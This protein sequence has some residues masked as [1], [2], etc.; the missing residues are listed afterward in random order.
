MR[1]NQGTWAW[2]LLATIVV[3]IPSALRAQVTTADI[4][5]TVTDVTGAAVPH[6]TVTITDLGTGESRQ[7]SSAGKGEF[8]FTTLP[9]GSYSVKVTATGFKTWRTPSV[10]LAVGDRLR[11]NPSLEVGAVTETVEVAAQTAGLQ[12]DS[13]S[14]GT[15]IPSTSVQNLPLNGRNFVTLVQL[16]AGAADST[17][18]FSA[19]TA[20]DDRRLTS[21]VQINGQFA[22]SNNYLIDGMDN[23]E[24]FIGTIMVK[25]NI[26]SIQE[27][28]VT[29]SNYSADLGRTAGGVIN[30]I[31]KSGTNDL[32][33]TAYEFFRN[34]AMDARNFFART[35]T[36]PVYGQN[37]Y[38]AS[39]GGRVIKDRTFFFM[40][41]EALRLNQATVTLSTVPLANGVAPIQP[42]AALAAAAG[43]YTGTGGERTG[44]F[45][46]I[47]PIYDP[48]SCP[49]ATTC[50]APTAG[51]GRTQFPN[52]TI[53]ANRIDAAGLKLLNFYPLPN[54]GATGQLTSNYQS[55]PV[56]TNNEDTMDVRV[57]HKFSEKNLAYVR[58]TYSS[59]R[60]AIAG[61]LTPPVTNGTTTYEGTHSL[62]FDIVHTF[63]PHLLM[64]IQSGWSRFYLA[65]LP[66]SYLKNPDTTQLGLP[67]INVDANSS[68][69]STFST[70]D[71][72][73][74]S[75]GD[76][77]YTPYYNIDNTY[78]I[79]GNVVR[80][81]GNHAFKTGAVFRYHTN[82]IFQQQTSAGSFAFSNIT[83]EATTPG[84][85][86]ISY[87]A[88]SGYGV[89]SMLL[90]YPNTVTRVKQL[91]EP[92]YVYRE[93]GAYA[94]D[95][96]RATRWLT[97]NLG[98]RYDYYGAAYT[99]NDQ[100]VN[101]NFATEHLQTADSGGYGRSAGVSIGA[102]N[103]SPRIGFAAT[104]AK[105]TVVHGGFA[106]SY[107]P[108]FV[109]TPG[110][111]RNAPFTS[112]FAPL[113]NQT[114]PDI[115]LTNTNPAGT[116]NS[117]YTFPIVTAPVPDNP[118]S[119]VNGILAYRPN[120]KLPY[121]LQTNLTVQQEI[122]ANTISLTYVGI[123]GRQQ[124]FPNA[125]IDVNQPAP[126]NSATQQTRR[127][128]YGLYPQVTTI[129]LY[130]NTTTNTYNG[131]QVNFERRLA[132]GL[133]STGN[134]TWAHALDNYEYQPLSTAT[135]FANPFGGYR[136]DLGNSSIDLRG[137]L[138][139][140][141]SYKLQ[142][143][144]HGFF[145]GATN[146]WAINA[147][148]QS[149]S[150]LPF[151][152]TNT[153]DVAGTNSEGGNRPNLVGNYTQ[154]GTI[155]GNPT[156]NAAAYAN[157]H[158]SHAYSTS[159]NGTIQWFNACAFAVQTTG[160]YGT[161]GR[162]QE[163]GPHQTG[164]AFAASKE[165]HIYD[166][167]RLQARGELFNAFNHPVFGLPSASL[168]S[169]AGQISSTAAGSLGLPRNVQLS[170]KFTF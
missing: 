118:N 41:Y 11:L 103:F 107:V 72:S 68:Q 89:A 93:F 49:T 1:R 20:V 136:L 73:L 143:K 2:I 66:G 101:F 125:S 71:S 94:Q 167:L 134:Y 40:D 110:S 42:N 100:I 62:A 17:V 44:N 50:A 161:L 81:S 131:F 82:L 130:G 147:I 84:S 37:Q 9:V 96:W 111:M 162:L 153:T 114:F 121:V 61:A 51:S 151:S 16:A 108:F 36:K 145:G 7:Q 19:G 140:T 138:A 39:V 86:P 112:Q 5:G 21:Q 156:C 53:P 28:R 164:L 122:G 141:V 43:A 169:T 25:P 139:V 58:Y 63:T 128:W 22:F 15:L 165:F 109:G 76:P 60:V 8:T 92:D 47:A 129:G 149:Q 155:A 14:V 74:T 105:K 87:V 52:S 64:E 126:G 78:E 157:V 120:A 30:M 123:F 99:T 133:E 115:S 160:T 48:T 10:T 146:G 154:P 80:Q 95:D 150:G 137:R 3:L 132:K 69:I 90:G 23:N 124:P 32:H 70:T 33:G 18:G 113:T 148:F 75:A 88:N 117:A 57:D 77:S 26:D 12:T 4:L 135:I 158:N 170:A 97:L 85:N 127:P 54:V 142:T 83:T 27:M 34:Q 106:T 56:T 152:V 168:S 67:N 29:S 159:G 45:S 119:P 65:S 163:F 79:N 31:T 46:G 24:R 116:A 104:V 166:R 98:V 144:F 13:S 38:G 35:G 59:I 55:A 6:A 102:L 91:S